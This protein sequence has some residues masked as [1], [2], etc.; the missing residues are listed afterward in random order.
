MQELEGKVAVVTGGGG[1]I[2]SAIARACVEAGMQV[3]V[4][5]IDEPRLAA[6][7]DSLGG[8]GIGV[9]G[10][11]T[12]V[13]DGASMEVLREAVLSRFEAIHLV[14]L[15]AGGPPIRM[16]TETTSA[17][18]RRSL[19]LNLFGVINGVE[20]FLPGLR[21]QGEGHICTTASLAGLVPVPPVAA[22]NAAK[23]AVI[24]YME[25]LG[26]ELREEGSPL[27]LSVVCPGN[28]ATNII[29]NAMQL[30][31]SDGYQPSE[32]ELETTFRAQARITEQGIE[33]ETVGRAV[34]EGVREGRF[35]IFTDPE[36]STG[37]VKLRHEAMVNDGALLS[38]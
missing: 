26:H 34:I 16:T 27:G 22:Y 35:W 12:D 8:E 18:W 10:V 1:G 37:A 15:N 30:V 36:M 29:E 17:Y 31:Q 4:A 20:A 6:T 38:W 3:V 5:D 19:E 9:Q 2:G 13:R 7:V 28:V 24:A 14:C 33:P 21:E 23:A 25:T 32:R 11:P